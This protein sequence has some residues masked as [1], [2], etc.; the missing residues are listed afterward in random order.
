VNLACRFSDTGDVMTA[1]ELFDYLLTVKEQAEERG[2][3]LADVTVIIGFDNAMYT[4]PDI[5]GDD[6]A[7]FTVIEQPPN[8][9]YAE[10]KLADMYPIERGL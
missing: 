7:V 4:L 1:Q 3:T 10:L 8:L 6:G 2:L 5:S 9:R